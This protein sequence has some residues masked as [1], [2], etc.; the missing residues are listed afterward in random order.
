VAWA[1]A[2]GL[3]ASAAVAAWSVGGSGDGASRAATAVNLAVT[4]GTATADLYPGAAGVVAFSVTNPNSFPVT[5]NAGSATGI[6]GITGAAG[7]CASSDFT[8]TTGAVAPTTIAAGATAAVLLTGSLTMKTTAG[9]GCQ[10]AVV[11]VT[12]TLSGSQA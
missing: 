4:A 10:S 2:L 11:A 1:V 6:S 5:V 7:A 9:D 12:A 8:L 3:P